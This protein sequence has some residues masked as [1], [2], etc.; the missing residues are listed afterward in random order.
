MLFSEPP[1]EE[2]NKAGI[3]IPARLNFA[4]LSAAYGSGG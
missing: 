4:I 3:F 1:L 2:T